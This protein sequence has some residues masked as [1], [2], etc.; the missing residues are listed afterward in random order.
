MKGHDVMGY[1]IDETVRNKNPRSYKETGPDGTSDFN[2]F[3]KESS[4]RFGSL[5]EVIH[6]S[7]IV[8]IAVQ[9]PHEPELEGISRLGTRRADFNYFFLKRAVNDLVSAV[10]KDTVVT[11]IS[12]VL[13]GT[14]RKHILPIIK[15]NPHI[16][17]CYNPF[18]IAMGTTMRDF[19][20]S[21]FIL[22]GEHD[23]KAARKLES[24]YRTITP[25]PFYRTTLENAELI[26]IAYNTFIGMKIV[27]ANVLMEVCHKTPGTDVDRV[28]DALKLA[29]TRLISERYLSGGMGDGGGCHPRD[30]IA[31]SWLAKK[32]KLSWNLFDALMIAR[33]KQTEWLADIIEGY[34]LP[35]VILGK[36]FKPETTIV[37][38]SPSLLLKNILEERGYQVTM[39]DSYIDKT[40]PLFGP[41]VFFIGTKHPDWLKFC[42][43]EGSVVIDPWRYIS[44]QTGIRVVRIGIAAEG[45]AVHRMDNGQEHGGYKKRGR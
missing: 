13:P 28:T 30:N 20:Q 37:A 45:A 3:L 31:M 2:K 35:K 16:K 11:I 32:L 24:F 15:Q 42:F 43:P 19:L 29:K 27:F 36:S 4:L 12:T 23:T 25:A 6:H 41:S 26:K 9:T 38:G 21:E 18:F 10:N 34:D 33:Q 22:C 40:V 7:E 39:Y 1:D 8:F 44:D 5:Q 17:L 14:I